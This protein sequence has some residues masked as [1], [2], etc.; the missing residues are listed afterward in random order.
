M[1]VPV[2]SR[3]PLRRQ[4]RALSPVDSAI[5]LGQLVEPNRRQATAAS[6][7]YTRASG[8]DVRVKTK[9]GKIVTIFFTAEVP[10]GESSIPV[11][12]VARP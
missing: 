9:R 12:F 2:A 6:S 1:I 5:E 3:Q 8:F 4:Q 11:Y 7:S 10:R